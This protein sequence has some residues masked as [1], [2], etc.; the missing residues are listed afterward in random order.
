MMKHLFLLMLLTYCTY[1]NAQSVTITADGN[2]VEMSKVIKTDT[3]LK[4]SNL[5]SLG[6][7][8]FVNVFNNPKLVMQMQDSDAGIIIGKCSFNYIDTMKLSFLAPTTYPPTEVDFLIKLSFRDARMKYEIYGFITKGGNTI[9]NGHVAVGDIPDIAMINKKKLR[10]YYMHSYI[11][12][13][14]GSNRECNDIGQ[15]IEKF[16]TKQQLKNDW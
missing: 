3:L 13:Q 14:L 6:T 4:K 1:S 9:K 8:W 5:Y 10:E 7:E 16:F 11:N 15:S 2:V 12:A